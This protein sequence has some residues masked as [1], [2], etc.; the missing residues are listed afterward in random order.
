[1]RFNQGFNS[2]GRNGPLN[3]QNQID[4]THRWKVIKPPNIQLGQKVYKENG[5]DI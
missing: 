4:T 1:M 2:Y 3:P 5:T